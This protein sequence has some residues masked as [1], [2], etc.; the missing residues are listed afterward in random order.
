MR[1][2]NKANLATAYALLESPQ[3]TRGLP[4]KSTYKDTC[5]IGSGAD[6]TYDYHSIGTVVTKKTQKPLLGTWAG[7]CFASW[8]DIPASH[9]VS[10]LRF[11]SPL[12]HKII[13][14]G[15][16]RFCEIAWDN[17]LQPCFHQF[18]PVFKDLQATEEL[19][20]DVSSGAWMEPSMYWRLARVWNECMDYVRTAGLVAHWYRNAPPAV[21]LALTSLGQIKPGTYFIGE[22]HR[23]SP[24]NTI[25]AHGSLPTALSLVRNF[26]WAARNGGRWDVTKLTRAK[27]VSPY[28]RQYG[29][30][31]AFW[32]GTGRSFKVTL[33]G[34]TPRQQDYARTSSLITFP[35][36]NTGKEELDDVVEV[37]T[38][39]YEQTQKKSPSQSCQVSL[40]ANDRFA[41]AIERYNQNPDWRLW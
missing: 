26:E 15:T 16:E 29:G 25:N 12:I 14:P 24:N 11:N 23:Q 18:L 36:V 4:W 7:G 9:R 37:L 13:P 35:D 34:L 1:L 40:K 28:S 41:E 3:F 21:L 5:D 33:T 39:V 17:V 19:A 20:F 22:S 32:F 10:V 2:L 38:D 27:L 6:G 8:R 30:H 31:N